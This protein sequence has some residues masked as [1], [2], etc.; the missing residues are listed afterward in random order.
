MIFP[1]F[2]NVL[3]FSRFSSKYGNLEKFKI[4]FFF[5]QYEGLN[6]GLTVTTLFHGS[7]ENII[8]YNLRQRTNDGFCV[9]ESQ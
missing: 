5:L 3:Y 8:L 6:L 1:G 4:V 2:P 7:L 9:N